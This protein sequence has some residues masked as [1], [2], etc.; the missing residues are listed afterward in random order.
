MLKKKLTIDVNEHAFNRLTAY[1]KKL[2]L[3]SYSLAIN[4]VID[5]ILGI[6]KDTK[7]ELAAFCA[8]K[9]TEI[10]KQSDSLGI[11]A[12]ND[13]AQKKEDY[14]NLLNFLT[15]GKGI[16]AVP[17][18]SNKNMRRIDIADGY[19]IF[20]EEWIVIKYNAP[21][22]CRYVG[23]VETMNGAKYKAPHFLL[24]S[25]KPINQIPEAEVKK[26]MQYCCDEYEPFKNI[27]EQ[28]IPAQYDSSN[29][30]LNQDEWMA[31]P[32]P[33]LFSIADYG[34]AQNYPCGA[35]VVR[36]K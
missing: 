27:L 22:L 16:P 28:E 11:F 31:A 17:E 30:L 4:T 26:I 9:L 18:T 24:F 6:S 33:G 13:A 25:E 14:T 29:H 12:R 15:D 2:N 32:H 36:T 1:R 8:K 21:Q 10:D 23:V 19:V 7:D 20:P 5:V 35:M 3:S 34:T